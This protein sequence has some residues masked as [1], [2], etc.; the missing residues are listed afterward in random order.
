MLRSGQ[1]VTARS[2]PTEPL[3]PALRALVLPSRMGVASRT[4]CSI[5]ECCPLMAAR[6]CRINFVLSVFPAPD[7]P[8]QNSPRE[9][10]DPSQS[11]LP[12]SPQGFSPNYF[13]HQA[14]PSISI[15]WAENMDLPG[16][17]GEGAKGAQCSATAKGYFP[18]P[19]FRHTHPSIHICHS[20]WHVVGA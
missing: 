12:T 18:P 4:C 9:R 2:A 15:Q 20:T 5:Q 14:P 19:S 7:S 1:R 16:L 10:Q 17:V 8:L 13:L 11:A 6:N 3:S